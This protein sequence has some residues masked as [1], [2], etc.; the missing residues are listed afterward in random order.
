MHSAPAPAPVPV[1]EQPA[2]MRIV[3]AVCHSHRRGSEMAALELARAL[4]RSG[5]RNRLVA[6]GPAL[7]GG[8]DPDLPPLGRSWR[9]GPT[10]LGSLAWG[11]RRLLREETVDVVVAHGSWPASVAA[12]AIPRH[13]PLVV[14]QRIGMLPDK[15]WGAIRRRWWRTVARRCHASVVLAA[16]Q[17][18][19]LRRLG[20][21][22]PVWVV[23]NFRDPDRFRD[24]DRERAAA[25]LRAEI[26]VPAETQLIGVVG[27]LSPEKRFDRALEVL[28]LLAAQGCGAHLVLAGSGRIR[29]ELEGHAERLGVAQ[30]VTFLGH[31]DDVERIFAGVDLALLTSDTECMPGVSVEALMAGCPM[32]TVPVGVV[33]RVVE[34]GVTGVVL[35]GFEPAEMAEAVARLLAD[36]ETRAAM[37]RE[38]RSRIDQFS[39]AAAAATYAERLSAA[40]AAR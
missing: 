28:A 13:G 4:D 38:S 19:E 29:A 1:V 2:R 17:E 16:D 23:P 8:I 3:H 21:D 32:V 7:D 12:L 37:S 34:D 25:G 36:H 11:L 24:V 20:F 10:E 18:V 35:H 31:R 22:G 14:W 40:L 30:S 33:D 9:E 26:G 5:H 27:A 6:M 39:A 15:V